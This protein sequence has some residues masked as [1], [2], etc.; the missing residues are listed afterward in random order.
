MVDGAINSDTHV[1]REYRHRVVHM[2][3]STEH[4]PSFAIAEFTSFN[5]DPAAFWI[6][7]ATGK[8]CHRF[9]EFKSEVVVR[10]T[11]HFK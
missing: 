10:G 9:Q 11:H 2:W 6:A 8:R 5:I 7:I 1:E 4:S 3:S